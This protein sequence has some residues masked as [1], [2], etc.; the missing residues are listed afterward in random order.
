[1]SPRP[2]RVAVI[3]L[4]WAGRTIWLPRLRAHPAFEVV[5][6]V[7]PE[8][9]QRASAARQADGITM[10]GSADEL[11][12]DSVDLAVVAV[13]N[14]LHAPVAD[15][16][17]AA[18]IPV[19]LEKPLCLSQAEVDQLAAAESAGGLLLGGSA[20]R[21]RADVSALRELKDS[22][23][24]IRH[25]ELSWRRARGVPTG[26]GWFTTRQL[27]GGGALVDLG[28]H[29]LDI[30]G[31]LLGPLSFE[32]V[33]GTV[34]ADFV[35]GSSFRAA[36]RKEAAGGLGDVEDTAHGFLVSTEGI[37]VALRASWASHEATDR[38]TF[39]LEGSEGTAELRCTLGFSPNRE[40]GSMLTHTVGGE[41]VRAERL[42]E[43]IGT[44]YDRQLD[45]LP[46]LLADPAGRGHAV[47]DARRAIDVIERIY[48]S[49]ALG[50]SR[51]PLPAAVG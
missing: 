12:P 7:E 23:G 9:V 37:S 27:A 46:A 4:G 17:L 50:R 43:P 51:Q 41:I 47:R 21:Y 1:M 31:F 15:Q 34:S 40:D 36:W 33:V 35:N 29:L 14:H 28:W 6:L 11:R 25:A 3:G 30:A 45:E 19:F 48:A 13:P 5:A 49:A 24:E 32:Q 38:T 18:G 26:A 44:E 20:A 22:L 39:R 10:Y 2:V 8:P 42:D 16:V